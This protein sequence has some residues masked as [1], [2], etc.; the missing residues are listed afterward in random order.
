MSPS[1]SRARSRRPD[2]DSPRVRT[3]ALVLAILFLLSSCVRSSTEA[4]DKEI[5]IGTHKLHLYCAGKGSPT[6]VIDTG[7]T[8]T[9]ES[10]MPLIDSLRAETVLNPQPSTVQGFFKV[11]S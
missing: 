10:W 3:I 9:Y 11:G 2:T 8:E 4:M 7:I 6:V 5:A 1:R